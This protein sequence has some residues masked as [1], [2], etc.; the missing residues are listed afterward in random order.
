MRY[1][2][3]LPL[4]I[5]GLLLSACRPDAP[6]EKPLPTAP[7]LEAVPA[8]YRAVDRQDTL[9][10]YYAPY[11]AYEDSTFQLTEAHRSRALVRVRFVPASAL[12]RSGLDTLTFR[13]LH[14]ELGAVDQAGY[15]WH[16]PAET[17][18]ADSLAEDAQGQPR[19]LFSTASARL[20]LTEYRRRRNADV[21][22]DRN[23]YLMDYAFQPVAIA[24]VS[25]SV[26][27]VRA[28]LLRLGVPQPSV[29]YPD[30]PTSRPKR[31]ISHVADQPD[32]TRMA[33]LR[34]SFRQLSRSAD[35]D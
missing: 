30:Y 5:G 27:Y 22:Y 4:A 32:T 26:V 17:Q 25:D 11:E 15:F 33:T 9:D 1:R 31:R 7:L 35:E 10:S 19:Q 34:L 28:F 20:V 18:Q 14:T 23:S 29:V 21:T 3:P 2:T 24:K 16:F 8:G 12:R 6:P 13:H